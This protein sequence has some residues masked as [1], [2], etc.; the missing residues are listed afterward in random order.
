MATRAQTKPVRI[1]A[2]DETSLGLVAHLTGRGRA[3][4]FHQAWIE[5]VRTHRTELA[6]VFRETQ[7]A[8]AAGD[9]DR[10]AR[11]SQTALEDQLDALVADLPT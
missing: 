5:Y 8:L 9:I 6:F 4:V 7:E 11:V 1:F 2:D 3:E 10:L